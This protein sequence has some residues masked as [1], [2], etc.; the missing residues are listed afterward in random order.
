MSLSLAKDEH[1]RLV[2][3][4]M[5]YFESMGLTVTCACS[6]NVNCETIKSFEPDV[7]AFDNNT[8]L[9]YIGEAK[10]CDN[11]KSDH[12]KKQF[13]EF[14]NRIMTGEKSHGADVPFYIIVPENCKSHLS[15]V[16]EEI[17]LSKNDNIHIV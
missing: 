13:L 1:Q 15:K 12:T 5:D 10:T 3:K 14:S 16:L 6:G 11:L 9:H 8:G 4:L 2:M 7:R 17:G